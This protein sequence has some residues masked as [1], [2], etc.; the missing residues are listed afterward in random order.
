MVVHWLQFWCKTVTYWKSHVL[1]T[2]CETPAWLFAF[3]GQN[4]VLQVSWLQVFLFCLNQL[5]EHD[6]H[7]FVIEQQSHFWMQ[8]FDLALRTFANVIMSWIIETKQP[9]K[10][11]LSTVIAATWNSLVFDQKCD[12]LVSHIILKNAHK[13]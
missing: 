13:F 4:K 1:V 10:E 3:S 11:I 5:K 6:K 7:C 9:E 2:I 8:S 12:C